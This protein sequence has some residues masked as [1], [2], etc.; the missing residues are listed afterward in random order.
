MAE[1]D[2]K[3]VSAD[4]KKAEQMMRQKSRIRSPAVLDRKSVV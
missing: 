4:E 2:M 1:R 3:A